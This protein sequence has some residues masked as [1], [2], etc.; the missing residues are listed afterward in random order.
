MWYGSVQNLFTAASLFVIKTRTETGET[1]LL[2]SWVAGDKDLHRPGHRLRHPPERS[3]LASRPYYLKD[4]FVQSPIFPQ[5]P[6][7]FFSYLQSGS[8]GKKKTR[9]VQNLLKHRRQD[10]IVLNCAQN[11][12]LRVFAY[13]T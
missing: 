13:Q 8:G 9:G 10:D 1:P 2:A 5:T 11:L 6:R 3:G 12:R 7:Y 4:R